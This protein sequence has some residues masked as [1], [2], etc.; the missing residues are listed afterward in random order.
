[1]KIIYETGPN[2]FLSILDS[3]EGTPVRVCV[4]VDGMYRAEHCTQMQV[5][6]VL[7]RNADQCRVIAKSPEED[8]G[9]NYTYF[10]NT[11]VYQ[12]TMR[13]DRKPCIY[14]RVDTKDS[15]TIEP[16]HGQ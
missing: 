10:S 15:V 9:M 2:K 8:E 4:S 3:L 12:I 5:Q 16:E 7:E 6:G 1:M 11:D 13:D 14:I